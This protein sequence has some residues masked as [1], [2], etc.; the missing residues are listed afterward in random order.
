MAMVR[1]AG[2]SVSLDG[3]GAGIEQ[4]LDE[5][6][7]KRGTEMFH[8]CFHTKSFCSMFGRQLHLDSSARSRGEGRAVTVDLLQPLAN[9]TNPLGESRALA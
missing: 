2:F 5:P 9:E 4:S 7:G 3:F 6:M 8:W 1:V